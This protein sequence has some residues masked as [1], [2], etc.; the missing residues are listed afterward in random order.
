MGKP[1]PAGPTGDFPGGKLNAEDEGGIVVHVNS[2][3]GKV[4]MVFGAPIAWIAMNPGQAAELANALMQKA[5]E[6]SG[7]EHSN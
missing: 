6:A 1:K 5:V 2:D 7:G 4:K 3:N